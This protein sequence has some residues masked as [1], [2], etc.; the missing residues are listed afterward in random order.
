MTDG[1]RPPEDLRYLVPAAL[2]HDLR[3]PLSQMLGYSEMLLEQAEEVKN[4]ELVR[5]LRKI[6]AAGWKLLA[7]MDANFQPLR[8]V[9]LED[10]SGTGTDTPS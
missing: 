9:V 6:R 2:L 4:E 10:A 3:T 5:D 7:L 1:E 8:V